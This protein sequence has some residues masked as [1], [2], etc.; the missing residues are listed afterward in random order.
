MK[1]KSTLLKCL[2]ALLMLL[3]IT[4]CQKK[5]NNYVKSLNDSVKQAIMLYV[6]END[7]NL[8]SRIITTDWV[9]NPYRTDVY[10]SNSFNQL[11]DSSSHMPTYYSIISDSII[12]FIYSGVERSIGRDTQELTNEIRDLLNEK[13]VKLKPDSGYINHK[14]TWLYTACGERSELIRT[15]AASDLFYIPCRDVLLGDTLREVNTY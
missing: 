9:A 12:V 15:P 10:I 3:T 14:H 5:K 6:N 1:T 11:N 4:S 2:A 8:E 13:N 7:I